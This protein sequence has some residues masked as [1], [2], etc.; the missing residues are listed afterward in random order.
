MMGVASAQVEQ[1]SLEE[2]DKMIGNIFIAFILG[3]L[4]GLVAV[5]GFNL[6]YWF[7]IFTAVALSLIVYIGSKIL[8]NKT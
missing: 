7:P 2:G 3:G 4:G 8:E 5:A 6:P 1:K